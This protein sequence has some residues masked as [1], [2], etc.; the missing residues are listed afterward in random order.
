MRALPLLLRTSEGFERVGDQLGCAETAEVAA[1][2]LLAAGDPAAAAHALGAAEGARQLVAAPVPASH[3]AQ[4]DRLVHDLAAFD[5]PRCLGIEDGRQS[6][7]VALRQAIQRALDRQ[8][9]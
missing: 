1:A 3:R 5:E 7:S 6:A 2:V 4:H 9:G 8:A